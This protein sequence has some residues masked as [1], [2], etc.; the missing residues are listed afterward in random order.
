[1]YFAMH[2]KIGN[3]YQS[4]C[5]IQTRNCSNL[6][7]TSVSDRVLMLPCGDGPKLYGAPL[8]ISESPE[9]RRTRRGHVAAL[10]SSIFTVLRTNLSNY[11][12]TK[13]SKQD[14]QLTPP[15]LLTWYWEG[16]CFH[17]LLFIIASFFWLS[18]KFYL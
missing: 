15:P 14:N 7:E 12:I 11:E 2:K 16:I 13:Q 10:L 5:Q 4:I 17:V 6:S 3:K 18:N 8:L 9:G 1:M